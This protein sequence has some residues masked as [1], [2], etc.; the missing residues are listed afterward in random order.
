[1]WLLTWKTFPY[2]GESTKT[3]TTIHHRC[4]T[5]S[6]PIVHRQFTN[7]SPTLSANTVNSHLADTSLL[8]TPRS[9]GQQQN[10][11][12]SY[13]CLTE[14]NSRYY[15]LSLP[16]TY[17]HFIRSQRHNF[18]VFSLVMADTE[19]HLGI[20]AY[21]VYFSAFWDCLCLFWS[22]SA[23]SVHQSKFPNLFLLRPSLQSRCHE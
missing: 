4:F 10:P 8:W 14:I 9:Y 3:T 6:W 18:I 19:Q 1:M 23:S 20:F 21:Q 2:Q 22:I 16:R 15:G 17:G 11:G 12:K 7:R 5:N 13:R